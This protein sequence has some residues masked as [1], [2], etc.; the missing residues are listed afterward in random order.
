MA[1]GDDSGITDD[2]RS[3]RTEFAGQLTQVLDLVW[4]EDDSRAWL[5][6]KRGHDLVAGDPDLS[7]HG[8]IAAEVSAL[9]GGSEDWL[10][11]S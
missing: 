7:S 2:E 4:T 5:I 1:G 3:A 10:F 11:I 8:A 6:I 9:L